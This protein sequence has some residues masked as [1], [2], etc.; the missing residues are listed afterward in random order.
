[1]NQ[2]EAA[3]RLP[4]GGANLAPSLAR[5]S[6]RQVQTGSGKLRVSLR[7]WD[8]LPQRRGMKSQKEFSGRISELQM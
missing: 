1:M 7:A 8:T 6:V 4:V 3:S 2:S 5:N